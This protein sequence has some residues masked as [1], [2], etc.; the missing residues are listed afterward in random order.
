MLGQSHG[1]CN[2]SRGW[3]G[4][5]TGR[6]HGTAADVEIVYSMDPAVSI[7][8]TSLWRI[9]HSSR[10]DMVRRVGELQFRYLVCIRLNLSN[11]VFVEE[12]TDGIVQDRDTSSLLV[13][14][15]PS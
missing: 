15:A 14:N 3:I 11:A 5:A 13:T 4:V 1:Q 12:L 6:K 2:N 7:H 9:T 10:A 8:D